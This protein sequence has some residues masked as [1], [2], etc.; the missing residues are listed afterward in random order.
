MNSLFM[1]SFW[2]KKYEKNVV[3]GETWKTILKKLKNLQK[4]AELRS[5]YLW[6]NAR[7]LFFYRIIW[8]KNYVEN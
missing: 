7:T 5:I 3:I 2:Y 8:S 4:N 6:F 1:V